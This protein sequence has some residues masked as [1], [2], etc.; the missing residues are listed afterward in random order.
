MV[1]TLAGVIDRFTQLPASLA[2]R[3]R[4]VDLGISRIP[5]LLVH[6]DWIAPAPVVLWMH[7]RT[8]YKELDSGRYLRWMRAGIA[9]VAIDL[10]GHGARRDQ[11][12]EDPTCTLDVLAELIR[13]IDQVIDALADPVWQGVFD[14][15]RVAIGGMSMGGMAT[16]RRLCDPHDFR[17]AVVECTSGDLDALYS[18]ARGHRPW[19]LAYP[20]TQYAPLDPASHLAGFKPVPLLALHSESDRIV[21]WQSQRGFLDRLREH[22]RSLGANPSLI[23][24]HTWQTTGA[25]E[26]HS[27]FG[28]VSNEAK[29]IQT[30]FLLKHLK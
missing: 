28:R 27:G 10:P 5:A 15:D 2:E 19:G 18:P 7:G 13:E 30:E 8:A 29:T 16:L 3:S 17:C 1:A 11:R 22:Y 21:P 25:P 4:T 26:E 20:T 14:L 24:Q 9:A 6:P 23:A 12:A